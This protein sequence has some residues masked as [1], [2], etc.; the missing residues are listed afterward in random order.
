MMKDKHDHNVKITI[1]TPMQFLASGFGSG[2]APIAPGTFG[3]AASIPVWIL[4]SFLSPIPYAMV[5]IA[6]FLLGWYVSEKAS[7]ELGVHDHGG[8]V[9]DEFVG[10]FIT[11]FL[12]PLS[13]INILLGFI[14][15]RIFDVIKPWPIKV[16][17][18]KVKGGFG[19]MIDDVFAGVMALIC[20]HIILWGSA[21]FF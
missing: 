6:T 9:I 15:F 1:R 2:C 13:W 17:D 4:L 21:Y 5:V 7:Q 3:T 11:M 20:M 18:Q 8:I 10:F 12:V 19:I 14:L 16:I